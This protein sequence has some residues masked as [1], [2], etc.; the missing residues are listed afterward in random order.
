MSLE[1]KNRIDRKPPVPYDKGTEVT[2]ND[3]T[4]DEYNRHNG[5]K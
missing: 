1:R 3:Y 5:H 2:T 4:I